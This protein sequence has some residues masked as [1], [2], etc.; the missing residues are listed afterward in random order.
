MLSQGQQQAASSWRKDLRTVDAKGNTLMTVP[1][2]KQL[3]KEQKL[4]QTPSLNDILYLHFKGFAEI[5]NLDAYTGLKTIWLE[6]N[7]LSKIQ[8]LENCTLLKCLFLQQNC[9]SKIENI[10]MLTALDTINLA[11]NMLKTIDNVAN[12]PVLT[13]LQLDHNYFTCADDIRELENC[14]ALTYTFLI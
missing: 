12:L 3:C 1:Y 2:I 5:Q 10:E 7:G 8:G 4:Y 13:T 6:G 11:H 9:I 14:K